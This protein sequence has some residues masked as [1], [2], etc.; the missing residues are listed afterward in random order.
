MNCRKLIFKKKILFFGIILIIHVSCYRPSSH[1]SFNDLKQLQGKWS[2][3]EGVLFNEHWW[4]VNDSLMAGIGFSL[5]GTDTAFLEKMQ[6]FV[7][8]DS[9]YFAA[10]TA[11]E[12]EY[13]R[14]AL[15]EARKNRWK[16]VNPTHDYPN[17]IQY[18]IKNDTLLNAFIANIRG[19]KK[20]EFHLKR[21]KN[22]ID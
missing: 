9:V 7:E 22:E 11:P 3:V 4:L 2:S 18:E 6:L 13:V 1:E 20:V 10:K 15:G 16:F 17:I 14:F 21:E 12:K 5:K 8:N 19:N